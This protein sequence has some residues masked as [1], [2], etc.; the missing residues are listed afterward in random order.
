MTN[1][2]APVNIKPTEIF[3]KSYELYQTENELYHKVPGVWQFWDFERRVGWVEFLLPLVDH[4]YVFLIEIS[5]RIFNSQNETFG[6]E[7]E[8][9]KEGKERI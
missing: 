6:G 1:A 3:S 7:V 5:N 4:L 2:T 8:K 9:G